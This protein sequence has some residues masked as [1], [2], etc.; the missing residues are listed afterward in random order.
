[1]DGSSVD[2]IV[3]PIV[4]VISLAVW[5]VMVYWADRD[6]L[7][8][9]R[10]AIVTS[11]QDSVADTAD[12]AHRA[13]GPGTVPRQPAAPAEREGVTPARQVTGSR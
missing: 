10:T 7:K 4:A 1:M 2:F 12:T 11:K 6:P 9:Q 3:I 5:L 8:S 13:A